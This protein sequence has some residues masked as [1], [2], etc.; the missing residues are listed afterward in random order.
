MTTRPTF[1]V[2]RAQIDDI[3]ARTVGQA[4]QYVPG[5]S[6][7][8]YGPYGSLTNYGLLGATSAQT[9]VLLNGSPVAAGSTGS[10]D[11]GNFSTVGVERIEV[12][13]G[14][15]STLYGSS[16]VGGIINIIT[17]PSRGVDAAVADGTLGNRD[18]RVDVGLGGLGVAYERHVA[19][20]VYDYPSLDGFPAGT[21]A[22][23]QAAASAARIDYRSSGSAQFALDA[24]IG[25]QALTVGVPGGVGFLT[26]EAVQANAATDGHVTLT[27]HAQNS[28]LS[29]TLSGARSALSYNDPQNGG[30]TDTYDARGQISL[31]DVV[32]SG[33]SSLVT[34]I[35]LS[36]ESALL[37]LGSF[38]VPPTATAAL[39][40]SA[41]YAQYRAAA[42]NAAIVTFGLRGE[43]DAPQG[44]VLVPAAGVSLG[45][46]Q[47]RVAVNYAQTFRVPTIDD[48][49]YPGFSNPSLVPERSQNLDASLR[50]PLGPATFS[51]DWFGRQATNLIA[52]DQN[53]VPQNIAQASLAGF[54]FGA[55]TAP[56]NGFVTT[57]GI[58]DMYRAQN[59]TPGAAASRLDFEPVTTIVLGLERP[60]RTN[61]TAFGVN[62]EIQSPH[63]EGGITRGGQTTIDAYVRQRLAHNLI[64]SLR[65]R[66]LGSERYAP[67]LGY[68]A[69]GRTV[70][71]ELAT[72]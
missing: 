35:D 4:L 59:L 1:V 71:V 23:A 19:T 45:A 55:R 7:F 22:N 24:G 72:K 39:A 27:R 50:M 25:D 15:G 38:N 65:G 62:A 40:Q 60:L 61:V 11:L 67:V 57:V 41:A 20:N 47:A 64:V 37:N 3:G 63:N 70:E 53:F 48:L 2:T 16:A 58:T 66:N 68:P 14:G 31:R 8:S 10:V 17:T 29:L 21:R 52:L 18:A 69:P 46:G 54:V 9:L 12:V 51:L 42:G 30:E 36:R 26:P 44:S 13:E 43:H 5:V 56:Y 34:G 33:S 28:A 6:L 32:G 49:Y